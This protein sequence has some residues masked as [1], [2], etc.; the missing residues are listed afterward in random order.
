MEPIIADNNVANKSNLD[1]SIAE[2]EKFIEAQHNALCGIHNEIESLEELKRHAIAR[3]DVVF[4][5]IIAGR[6]DTL[7]FSNCALGLA[8]MAPEIDWTL[9]ESNDL[10]PAT[11]IRSSKTSSSRASKM[12]NSISELRQ[13][14]AQLPPLPV[15][16]ADND[17]DTEERGKKRRRVDPAH[18]VPAAP[19]SSSLRLPH[20]A[21]TYDS[22]KSQFSATFSQ[23]LEAGHPST[24][25][26][27]TT[28]GSNSMKPPDIRSQPYADHPHP[29]RRTWASKGVSD[30]TPVRHQS[31]SPISPVSQHTL[32]TPT[33]LVVNSPVALATESTTE[34]PD[35]RDAP[36][37]FKQNWTLAEQHTLERL[38]VEIPSTVK[39]RWVRISE[40]MGG[41]RTPRQV[42]SRVQK[43]YE[44][45]KKLGVAVN[46]DDMG[47]G[48]RG[49]SRATQALDTPLS[50]RTRTPST[51]GKPKTGPQYT[52]SGRRR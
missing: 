32:P 50:M 22:V 6:H 28:S 26:S 20:P 19:S 29:Q 3:P 37:T 47:G 36:T 39:F 48:G 7:K 8:V 14:L 44:K 13:A 2:L 17:E 23:P 49:G 16:L 46:S 52:K 31:S 43:Y 24:S 35:T 40:A 4:G 38:L 34:L 41:T 11:H 12:R 18:R 42:A 27:S 5:D 10:R 51:R 9:L 15:E 33:Q 30:G 21:D 45:M 1:T 25:G